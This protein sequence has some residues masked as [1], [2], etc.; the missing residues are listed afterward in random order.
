MLDPWIADT[1]ELSFCEYS[2]KLPRSI[3]KR[4]GNWYFLVTESVRE[5][6]PGP[7][8]SGEPPWKMC[9]EV[10]FQSGKKWK[11]LLINQKNPDMLWGTAQ[12]R[13]PK[14]WPPWNSSFSLFFFRAKGKLFVQPTSL[15]GLPDFFPGS[16]PRE[17]IPILNTVPDCVCRHDGV[18]PGLSSSKGGAAEQRTPRNT[19]VRK[20]WAPGLLMKFCTQRF[21]LID[22]FWHV[23]T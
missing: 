16:S 4:S 8:S 17:Q 18:T 21:Q 19:S 22:C 11:R 1:L 15:P 6:V 7:G 2:T 23:Y 10:Q 14:I 13:F 3:A 12:M 5:K 20:V 9:S